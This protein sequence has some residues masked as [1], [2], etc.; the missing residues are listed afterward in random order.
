MSTSKV[1]DDKTMLPVGTCLQRGKYRIDRYLSSGG[2]GNT[3]LATNVAFDEP[4]AIKEF[5]MRELSLRDSE[6]TA[7]SVANTTNL[8]VFQEQKEK[9][10]KEALR[11]RNLHSDHIVAVSDLFDENDTSYYVMDYIDG[12]SLRDMVESDGP[13]PEQKVRNYLEQTL[14]ALEV[15]HAQNM[16]HLDLKPANIMVDTTGRV[17]VIDF[18]ASKQQKDGGI[19]SKSTVCYTPGYAPPEQQEQAMGKFGAYT[20]IYAL[21]ATLYYVLTG[22]TPPK[23]TD[24][25]DEGEDA[26]HFP[27]TVSE[28]MREL[29]VWMMKSVRKQ[30]P[31]SVADIRRFLYEQKE[32]ENVRVAPP[33]VKEEGDETVL[34]EPLSSEYPGQQVTHVSPENESLYVKD[35][36][37]G[38]K[39][40]YILLSCLAVAVLIV[41]GYFLMNKGSEGTTYTIGATA[42]GED[43]QISAV[44][45]LLKSADKIDYYALG[46]KGNNKYEVVKSIMNYTPAD[47]QVDVAVSSDKRTN[48]LN[49]VDAMIENISSSYASAK[50]IFL[51]QQ[52]LSADPAVRSIDDKLT[53]FNLG[54]TYYNPSSYSGNDAT[55][56]E[57]F[58]NQHVAM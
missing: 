54:I 39:M 49:K 9:F 31:Q 17:R 18:G 6:T 50:I 4:V 43:V 3:Y 20:D 41:G 5:F 32:K 33:H 47:K 10:R 46:D 8:P 45:V 2:F 57:E 52:N 35:E 30:R 40:K 22:E 29:I 23:T 15:V 13:L 28:Q 51:A 1:I 38:N 36:D 11:L 7:V 42:N 53:S 12:Q 34:A 16:Y 44:V 55:M 27:S 14:E 37:G 58:V 25:S 26:F 21:G 56:V 19:Y 24:I 48:Q